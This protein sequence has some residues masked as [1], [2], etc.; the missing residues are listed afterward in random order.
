M[1][2][3]EDFLFAQEAIAQGFVTEAQ[4]EEAL[5]LQRRMAEDL[6]LDERLGV[7]LVKRGYLAEDQARRVY[8]RIDPDKQ[9]EIRGYRLL[10]VI[11]RGAMG[12][13]Y[14]ALHLGLNRVVALKILRPDLRGD[15]T[16]VERLKAE[17]AMLASLDHPNVVRALDAG[18]SNG[19]PYFVMEF[20]EGETLR[21]RLRREGALPEPE[22][23]R[24]ARGIADALERA[25]RMG[26]VHRD[27]KPGNVLLARDGTP[28]IMDLGLA[29][30]PI[31]LGLTQHG[32]TVG[33]PQYISPE[34]AVDPRKADTRSDIYG[35]GA[36]LYAMLC[37]EPPFDGQTLA[38]ILTKVLYE[39]PVPVR[40]RRPQVSPEAG[41]LVERMMLKDPS[42]RHKTPA[43]VV[44]D[45][46]RIEQGTSILPRGFTGSWEGWL[47]RAR[48]R[49]FATVAVGAVA[50]ALV[51][52]FGAR[53]VV[54]RMQADKERH[55]VEEAMHVELALPALSPHDRVEDVEA[56][57]SRALALLRRAEAADADDL[58]ALRRR[59]ADLDQEGLRFR[60]LDYVRRS[61]VEPALER[62]D[63]ARA[64][65]QWSLAIDRVSDRTSP[66][67]LRME[68][69]LDAVRQR[70]DDALRAG[71]AKARE[72]A[73][74][75]FAEVVRRLR[76]WRHAVERFAD[77]ALA[78]EEV[79]RAQ[80]ALHGAQEVERA[81]ASAGEVPGD[82]DAAREIEDLRLD[83]VARRFD[84]RR[85][86][87]W[88]VFVRHDAAM[89]EFLGEV[90]PLVEAPLAA[91]HED[92]RRRVLARFQAVAARADE[93]D[94]QRRPV[95][96]VELLRRVEESAKGSWPEVAQRARDQI[97]RLERSSAA[98]IAQA[99]RAWEALLADV[100][101]AVRAD[102]ADRVR[103]HVAAARRSGLFP[104]REEGMDRL[105]EWADLLRDFWD[106]VAAGLEARLGTSRD[107]WIETVPL[108]NGEREFK[109]EVRSVDRARRVVRVV[110]HSGNLAR[111]EE[112]RAFDEVHPDF[113]ATLADLRPESVPR[114][115]AVHAAY[116]V[117]RLPDDAADF[118]DAADPYARREGWRRVHD[119][120]E[121]AERGSDPLARW[122]KDR[123]EAL[124]EAGARLEARAKQMFETAE[125]AWAQRDNAAAWN[126]YQAL[127]E[128]PLAHALF[129][130]KERDRVLER[131]RLILE[132]DRTNLLS[133][134][135]PD[136]KV[137]RLQGDAVELLFDF[138]GLAQGESFREGSA[139]FVAGS[140][141]SPTTPGRQRNQRLRILPARD[142]GLLPDGKTVPDRP[143][144]LASPLDPT[145]ERS[146]S[147][148]LWTYSPFFL[149]L[150]LDGVQAGVLSA[151]PRRFRF[152]SDVPLL[153]DERRPPPFDFYG[154]GRGVVFRAGRGL[155]DPRTW[156]QWTE[157][158]HGRHFVPP[159][160]DRESRR[161]EMSRRWFAFEP[162][163]RPYRVRFVHT[164]ASGTVRLEVDDQEVW[165][166]TGSEWKKPAPSG[167]L[168]ILCFTTCDIDDL[169]LRGHVSETW[170]HDAM[171][172]AGLSTKVRTP[173]GAPDAV[174]EKDK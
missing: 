53:F 130:K 18:E 79:R 115:A 13:V 10:D 94:A 65:A 105:E 142:G 11:G 147:F 37:G 106:R 167:L 91:A 58:D 52:A 109:W 82:P 151:D 47:L 90:R 170:R 96:G 25:R 154:L 19:Y 22:A 141:A 74:A 174:S 34:Q 39:A 32:A 30:G 143:L 117:S 113:L 119:R 40:T 75:T 43:Q 164:P 163:D 93:L 76:D 140:G 111:K 125:A 161:A 49:R 56:R 66:A 12:T 134:L 97:G 84:A 70:S 108:A 165:S 127:L 28:K 107:R 63:W 157:G 172:R 81:L 45:I 129:A 124:A 24:I 139:M 173:S 17:A 156:P 145:R 48:T 80:A 35:L 3:N 103:A 116:L 162:Q 77:T 150:D 152:E 92:L 104:G 60:N 171:A 20:V 29:K 102:D 59:V 122:T 46:D 5:L 149:G 71:L 86:L 155:G 8:A 36:T 41:Y 153:D 57:L 137:R 126:R 123:M 169:V 16:Q 51:V 133:L 26:I 6:K 15:E 9:G 27:V 166:E 78:R 1:T 131:R 67:R 4:V 98:Q 100:R 23:L 110:S 121:Q 33:T 14:R 50:A 89:R 136:A 95:E 87:A 44:A 99:E 144:V 114:D 7:I 42:L 128:P 68:E 72:A 55:V 21:D 138:D 38:E 158:N 2:R 112:A 83:D 61:E 64:A 118:E 135:L 120:L 159:D 62:G 31:D 88:S 146:I 73:P 132:E 69:A 160:R 101:R 168:Q 85:A 54:G 148:H